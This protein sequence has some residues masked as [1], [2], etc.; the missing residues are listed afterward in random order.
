MTLLCQRRTEQTD[1]RNQEE[2]QQSE[3]HRQPPR[4]DAGMTPTRVEC[5]HVRHTTY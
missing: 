1:T 2:C 4:P 3:E 5:A